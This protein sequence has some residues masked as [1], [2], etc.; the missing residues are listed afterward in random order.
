MATPFTLANYITTTLRYAGVAF[1]GQSADTGNNT[2][3]G[4]VEDFIDESDEI[5]Q[6]MG[7]DFNT[8]ENKLHE[9][10]GN[11]EIEFSDDVLSIQPVGSSRGENISLEL[12]TGDATFK[13]KDQDNDTFTLTKDYCLDVVTKES[14]LTVPREIMRLI[15]RHAAMEYLDWKEGGSERYLRAERAYEMELGRA[16]RFNEQTAN[17][18]MLDT[19]E[20]R[21][22]AGISYNTTRTRNPNA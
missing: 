22:V 19:Y 7:W 12:D 9:R 6:A 13:V 16:R 8:Q 5:I 11:D 20:A 21:S 1:K 14:K 2:T 15:C 4:V 3:A 10:D 18:N 17:T